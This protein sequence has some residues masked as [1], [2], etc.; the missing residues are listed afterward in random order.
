ML[1]CVS[2]PTFGPYHL[3]RL[4]ASSECATLTGDRVVGLQIASRTS[5]RPNWRGLDGSEQPGHTIFPGADYNALTA[6][7]VRQKVPSALDAVN[8]DAV[9]ING[10][11]SADSRAALRWCRV[12]DRAAI[13]MMPSKYDDAIRTYPRE[14]A[15]RAIIRLFDSAI[16]GGTPQR[17]YLSYLG[18]PCDRIFQGY[19]VV[20]NSAFEATPDPSPPRTKAE[21]GDYFLAVSRLIKRKNIEGLIEAYRRYRS[22]EG[23]P[24]WRLIVVG[25]GPLLQDLRASTAADKL[26]TILFPGNLPQ[27]QVVPLYNQAAAFVHPALQ[28]Q[29]GLVVNEAMA[30]SLPVLVSA[31]SGCSKDLVLDGHNGFTFDAFRTEQL[32]ALLAH[33]AR[34]PQSMRSAMGRRSKER[35]EAYSPE[36]FARQ[37]MRAANCGRRSHGSASIAAAALRRRPLRRR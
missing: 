34:L 35:I 13:L 7:L 25:D 26:N 29:W 30:S 1:I 2:W 14:L 22:L 9:A 17:T 11:A 28:D 37:L 5:G 3:A 8:P 24:S 19:N 16:V 31:Q 21:G 4:R 15:K 33:T 36:L 27:D 32:A 18:F 23:A 12:N 6:S 10:Y 20:D